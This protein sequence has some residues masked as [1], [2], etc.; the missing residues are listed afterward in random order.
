MF[1]LIPIIPLE[2]LS[3]NGGE[4]RFM[5]IKLIRLYTGLRI[6]YVPDIMEKIKKIFSDRLD[7]LIKDDPI[8]A[9]D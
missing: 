1:D 7:K 2:F 3:L 4:R 5:L 9:E 8:A 6:F